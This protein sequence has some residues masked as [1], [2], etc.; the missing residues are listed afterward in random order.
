MVEK[1]C[2]HDCVQVQLGG[3]FDQHITVLFRLFRFSSLKVIYWS[4][5]MH[6]HQWGTRVSEMDMTPSVL[7]RHSRASRNDR[8]MARSL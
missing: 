6:C 2:E 3:L 8:Y 4:L 7:K 1:K 5:S